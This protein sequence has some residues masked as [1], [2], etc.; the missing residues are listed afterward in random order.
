MDAKSAFRS[1]R[2][3]ILLGL[4][5][6]CLLAM[7][8]GIAWTARYMRSPEFRSELSLLVQ[9]ATGR[10]V[11]IDGELE[12]SVFPWLGLTA[13][14]LVLG[15]AEGFSLSPMLRA[16]IIEA[17]VRVLALLQ[18]ELVLDTVEL[19]DVNLDLAVLPDGR[20]NWESLIERY[21]AEEASQQGVG[22]SF[23]KVSLRGIHIA[24]GSATL[25]DDQHNHRFEFRELAL[26]TGLIE[27]GKPMP[28]TLSSD[29]NWPRPA[30][31]GRIQLSGKLEPA[32]S[33]RT[34]LLSETTVQ[35]EVGGR[36]L[37]KGAARAG[38]TAS[39]ELLEGNKH[40]KLSGLRLKALGVDGAGHVTFHDFLDG[41]RMT[42]QLATSRF[43]PRAV[44]NAYWPHAISHK[45]SGA[46][47]VVEG[48]LDIEANTEEL[49]FHNADIRVDDARLRGKARLGF[50]EKPGLDF[51]LHAD[52]LDV[53][54]YAAALHSNSTEQPLVVDDLPMN[55]LTEV[56]G[57]GR[58]QAE[59]F[60]LA[61]VPAKGVEIT[62]SA[63]NGLHRLGIQPAKA[64]GGV[65]SADATVQFAETGG[66]AKTPVLGLGATLR[67]DGVDARQI[68]WAKGPGFSLSGRTEV[69]ARVDLPKTPLAPTT[70]LAQVLR[71]LSGSASGTV[72]G[73]ALD[74]AEQ[75]AKGGRPLKA[76][77]RMNFS[78]LQAQVKLTPAQA[79]D[80]AWVAQTDLSVS[81]VGTK[82]LVNLD[83]KAS[84]LVRAGLRGSGLKLQNALISGK[85][86][87]WFLPA[88][89][90][91]ATFS[92][93]GTLDVDAQTLAMASSSVQI[94]GLNIIGPFTVSKLFGSEF[95]IS[96]RVHSQD[97]DPKR[98]LAALDIRQPKASDKRVLAK[99]A[100]DAD[101]SLNIKG[102]Q[103]GNVNA[104]LDDTPLRG[105]FALANYDKPR[106][107]FNLQAGPLDLDR[108]VAAPVPA[109]EAARRPP[110]PPDPLPVDSLRDLIA[111][112]T[113]QF[114]AFKF[115][116]ITA[117]GLV[118]T[119]KAADG[120]LKVKP[121]AGKFYGGDISGELMAQAQ[122]QSMQVR[123]SLA[124]KDFY[125]SPFM[126]GWAGKEY[127]T[128]KADMF[129]DV[130]GTGTTDQEV[131]R[132]L[133]GMSGFKV[134]EGSYVLTGAQEQSSQRRPPPGA[135][136]QSGPS[137]QA[138]VSGQGGKRPGTPFHMASAQFR[139]RRGQ[140]Q[141]DDF[142][143]EAPNMV[144]T[145]RGVFSLQEETI[146][147]ALSASMTGI[148]D[149]PV[150]VRGRL[151]D[152][153]IA[154]PPGMLIDNTIKEIMGLPF[155]PF[156]F[157]KDMLF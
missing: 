117:R 91:E 81:A 48:K 104:Q 42:G 125:V 96:G 71:K 135:T 54:A 4:L 144:V 72:A 89:E 97:S 43:D 105:S 23:R 127:A 49:A 143:M 44:L 82:P 7:G 85:L 57:K 102:F 149:V 151:R 139:V 148:P 77:Q 6:L 114:R 131:L 153:E 128:G 66:G 53:D 52:T 62:W 69:R 29:V 98:L 140:F 138:G 12:V 3:R 141:S 121:L 103:L 61:G 152:P 115:Y 13:H 8:V 76:A 32:T 70:K 130:G 73:A 56:V 45:H 14:G 39:L 26:R 17:R 150:R 36:F 63:E 111:D 46:L 34:S 118:A 119:V 31:E 22:Q 156:K 145:G 137:G 157:L 84:G 93:R 122:K 15:N 30:L 35:A 80:E 88:R 25:Q 101:L 18:R 126:I 120:L 58:V 67:M 112:G 11:S 50:G 2:L 108:Y 92:G 9:H 99:L 27:T 86:R 79:V 10:A 40:L 154:I 5:A 116:G 28:F 19:R 60:T 87:G 21:R 59:N 83:A 55:Y 107:S 16:N 1:T 146:D 37:P 75:P 133:E 78:S 109:A 24:G 134:L 142:R 94:Y 74:W 51:S 113:I 132:T 33:Q 100:G 38:L 106:L 123:L 110:P 65:V 64:Q 155:K 129:V 90:S 41:F 20:T 124:A 147:F 95:L 47:K 136:A 68:A